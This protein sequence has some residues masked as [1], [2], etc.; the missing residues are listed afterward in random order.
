M[1]KPLTSFEIPF[2]RGPNRRQNYINQLVA[3]YRDH[4]QSTLPATLWHYTS[5]KKFEKILTSNEIWFG[6]VSSM[7]DAVEVMRAIE[8]ANVLIDATLNAADTNSRA[9]ILLNRMKTG[10]LRSNSGS[11]WY[12]ASFTE[13]F[14]DAAQWQRF[15]DN[16]R[17]VCIEFDTLELLKYLSA[18]AEDRLF[19]GKVI[20][21]TQELLNFG[22][23]L[24]AAALGNFSEDFAE[25]SDDNLAAEQ[26]VSLWGE[27]VDVFSVIPKVP[28]Y[29]SEREWR[30]A[31]DS[32][33]H[34]ISDGKFFDFDGKRKCRQGK[35]VTSDFAKSNLPIVS[36]KL[37]PNSTDID[38]ELTKIA[39]D[40]LGHSGMIVTKSILKLNP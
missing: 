17:G 12:I 39:L 7:Q 1:V 21:D 19:L 35:G 9:K 18:S 40:K 16:Y 11:R 8:L 5:I 30:F 6:H 28:S 33:Q 14:E 34:Q 2:F 25:V 3:I 31:L 10:L 36:I 22:S 37:G 13:A 27:L 26:F 29:S 32:S 4:F 15:G 24:L 20:Y 23:K 38:A